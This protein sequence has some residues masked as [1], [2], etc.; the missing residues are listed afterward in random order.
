MTNPSHC[1]PHPDLKVVHEYQNLPGGFRHRLVGIQP[2]GHR[3][4]GNF[5][6]YG[7]VAILPDAVIS[8]PKSESGYFATTEGIELPLPSFGRFG[9]LPPVETVSQIA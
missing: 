5:V 9:A 7:E 6:K 1:V 3:I 2:D 4:E 8:D